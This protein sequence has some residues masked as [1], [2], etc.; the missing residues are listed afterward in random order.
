MRSRQIDFTDTERSIR[1]E[2]EQVRLVTMKLQKL[3]QSIYE[4][5][6]SNFQLNDA[7][8]VLVGQI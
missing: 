3:E 4:K 7:S 8:L 1:G 6:K 2:D 5:Q